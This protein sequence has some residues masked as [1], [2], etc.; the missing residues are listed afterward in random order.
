ML[1][2]FHG[3]PAKMFAAY[4]LV[5]GLALGLALVTAWLGYRLKSSDLGLKRRTSELGILLT[6]S[7]IQAGVLFMIWG[8]IGWTHWLQYVVT[9]IITGIGYKAAHVEEMD[10]YQYFIVAGL[11][12]VAYMPVLSM[13]QWQWPFFAKLAHRFPTFL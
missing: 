2:H 8:L 13:L 9:I 1:R 4:W 11:Q 3:Q 12:L 7:A 10:E 6:V 5:C